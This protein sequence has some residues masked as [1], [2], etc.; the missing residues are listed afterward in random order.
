MMES[1]NPSGASPGSGQSHAAACALAAGLPAKK[2]NILY[3]IVEAY[4]ETGEAVS[5]S[6]IAQRRIGAA[7]ISPATIR[8]A[9]SELSELGLLS[10]PH[11]SAGRIPTAAAIQAYVSSLQHVRANAGDV[12]KLQQKLQG[13]E[14]WQS[15]VEEGSHVLTELARN[16]A[17]TAALPPSSEVL[18]QV[19]ILP[20]SG[21]QYLLVVIT[22]DRAVHNHVV[23]LERVLDPVN[24]QQMRNYLNAEF[25]GWALAEARLE[26]ERRLRAERG[27]YD[28]LLRDLELF[29]RRGLLHGVSAPTVYLDGAAYLVGLDLHLTRERMRELFHALEQKKQILQLLD[30]YLQQGDGMPMVQ[31]GLGDAHPAMADLSLVGMHVKLP[32]GM[33]ARVA[34]LGP[35]RLNYARTIAAV[36]EV[37]QALSQA[38]RGTGEV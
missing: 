20:L 15:R 21:T 23:S 16:V 25:A 31:V 14:S 8:N 32:A 22:A 10:Q 18:H 26:I 34:V 12:T 27:H 13:I 36:M 33:A 6:A 35:L 19:E 5:S 24:L 28:Q 4:L 7:A 30:Q 2:R 11:T 3:A 9:M 29:H 37:S 1:L 38:A 17:I